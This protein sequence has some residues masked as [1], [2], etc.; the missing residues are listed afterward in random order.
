[1]EQRGQKK[2]SMSKRS[3]A[4]SFSCPRHRNLENPLK[5]KELQAPYP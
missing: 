1:V 3:A 4:N 2:Q 5:L